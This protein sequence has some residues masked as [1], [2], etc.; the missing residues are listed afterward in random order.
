M[1]TASSGGDNSPDAADAPPNS[2]VLA[3]RLGLVLPE[4]LAAFL[5]DTPAEPALSELLYRVVAPFTEPPS[6]PWAFALL[7]QAAQRPPL[8]LVPVAP[9]DDR[10]IACVVS[11]RL[12]RSLPADYGAVVRW[13]LDDI[14]ARAQR[15]LL[16]VDLPSYLETYRTEITTRQQG[17]ERFGERVAEY[18][19]ARGG[20]TPRAHEPRPIRKAC[21]NV[22][23]GQGNWHH[24]GAFNGLNVTD[25]QTCQVPHVAAYEG[26]RGLL[27]STLAEAFRA[28][29][30]MEVRFDDHLERRVPA[31]LRQY[32]RVMGCEPGRRDGQA[33]APEEAREL[34]LAVT[35]MND[36]LREVLGEL[37]D[38]LD[39]DGLTAERHRAGDPLIAVGDGLVRMGN[40]EWRDADGETPDRHR[41]VR[42]ERRRYAHPVGEER[43]LVGADFEPTSA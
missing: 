5:D 28:G 4:P 22:V 38:F 3:E 2:V 9:V 29:G 37:F 20:K 1:S 23:I 34:M 33:I 31:S 32:G 14:P 26:N 16:D 25:W 18:D 36:G 11:G 17:L 13:H 30:T 10:S 40:V 7:Q 15:A 19:L 27:A 24:D 42:R 21:Q 35:P 8:E 6:L 43:D 12:G 41:G 39:P